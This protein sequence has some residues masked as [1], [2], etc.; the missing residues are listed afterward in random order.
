VIA[1][2]RALPALRQD[3]W[4]DDHPQDDGHREVQWLAPARAGDSSCRP[5]TLDDWHDV[6]DTHCH[7]LA[8]WL[9]PR[10]ATA[11]L[12]LINADPTPTT[13][14]LP[15]GRWTQHIDSAQG[16]TAARSIERSTIEVPAHGLL[17]LSQERH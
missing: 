5:M 4:L 3:Q 15:P 14:V 6:H 11:V 10:A 7:A 8:L 16:D 2:R 9:A 12:V 13:F 17:V 1:L